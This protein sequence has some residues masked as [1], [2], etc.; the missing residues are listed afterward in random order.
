MPE[1]VW[2]TNTSIGNSYIQAVEQLYSDC[3]TVIFRLWNSYIQAV[4][5]LYSGCGT[6]I[7]RLWNSYIQTVEQLYSG[8]PLSIP[9]FQHIYIYIFR[10]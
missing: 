10:Y 2:Y 1:D 3:G 8:I 5:Q 7:F 6:V 4:E 9:T